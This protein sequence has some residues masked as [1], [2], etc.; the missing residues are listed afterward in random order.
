MCPPHI[1]AGELPEAKDNVKPGF[2][3]DD[4]AAIKKEM[5]RIRKEEGR[6]TPPYSGLTDPPAAVDHVKFEITLDGI[7]CHVSKY[8]VDHVK[9]MY[10]QE[11]SVS[12]TKTLRDKIFNIPMQQL[13][14]PS[15]MSDVEYSTRILGSCFEVSSFNPDGPVMTLKIA[16]LIPRSR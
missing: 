8:F 11:W 12:Q 9:M 6:N 7:A 16:P 3:A 1:P 4:A 14:R 13:P 15:T 2:I 5:E 10:P